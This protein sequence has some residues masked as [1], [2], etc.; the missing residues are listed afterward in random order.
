M[1]TSA[2]PEARP[3]PVSCLGVTLQ[4][5]A[6]TDGY[7]CKSY[8]TS[9]KHESVLCLFQLLN[10]IFAVTLFQSRS[11]PVPATLAAG[12]TLALVT[13]EH[14]SPFT[15]T[16]MCTVSFPFHT[17]R[18][19]TFAEQCCL[20]ADGFLSNSVSTSRSVSSHKFNLNAN[21]MLILY[22]YRRFHNGSRLKK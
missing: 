1:G 2:E 3:N 12:S 16:S 21:Y 18:V 20:S 4:V 11:Y 17:T 14:I 5:S 8:K 19:L 13:A 10:A 6:A 15:R 7:P 9:S 22:T